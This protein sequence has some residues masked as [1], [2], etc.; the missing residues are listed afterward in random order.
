M[1]EP[2]LQK[3]LDPFD[4]GYEK[5][6]I[7]DTLCR[8]SCHSLSTTQQ[9]KTGEG[10]ASRHRESRSHSSRK[11]SHSKREDRRARTGSRRSNPRIQVR[12]IMR[13]T[14]VIVLVDFNFFAI[15]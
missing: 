10:K 4:G 5:V 2:D 8:R 9:V 12:I 3:S 7:V 6:S 1:G 11:R 13:L 14:E 15:I